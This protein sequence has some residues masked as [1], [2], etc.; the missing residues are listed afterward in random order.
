M[1]FPIITHDPRPPT[2]GPKYSQNLA[3]SKDSIKFCFLPEIGAVSQSNG[4]SLSDAN[5]SMY[6]RKFLTLCVLGVQTPKMRRTKNRPK[7]LEQRPPD[8]N[9]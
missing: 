9:F 5:N 3:I 6:C 8:R 7:N 4:K 1:Q 2:S